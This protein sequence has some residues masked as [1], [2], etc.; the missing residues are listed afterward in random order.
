M[1]ERQ[2]IEV[3]EGLHCHHLFLFSADQ[4]FL[5]EPGPEQQ[6]TLPLL[7]ADHPLRRVPGGG[8]GG[9]RHPPRV[10]VR[11]RGVRGVQLRHPGESLLLSILLFHLCPPM[12][13][14]CSLLLLISLVM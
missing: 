14:F 4:L 11:L 8:H 10:E 5:H 12:E 6:R 7:P 9:A 3:G 2:G 1:Q 13:S